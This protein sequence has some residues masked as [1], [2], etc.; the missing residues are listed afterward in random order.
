MDHSILWEVLPPETLANKL[1]GDIFSYITKGSVIVIKRAKNSGILLSLKLSFFLSPNIPDFFLFFWRSFVNPTII[2]CA[3]WAIMTWSI[4]H[5]C[6]KGI[7]EITKHR[8]IW[9]NHIKLRVKSIE[10][11][12]PLL[13]F[14]L[15]LFVFIFY[16]CFDF[17]IFSLYIFFRSL[18]SFT[19][20][21][22]RFSKWKNS[23]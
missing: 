3:T 8:V 2:I 10:E 17:F 6:A 13:L 23:E 11:T 12:Y 19:K 9:R 16:F 20:M 7:K 5:L 14:S 22:C 21:W 15:S 18:F 4:P 1:H